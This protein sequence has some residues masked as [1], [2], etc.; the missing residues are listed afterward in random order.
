MVVILAEAFNLRPAILQVSLMQASKVSFKSN[1]AP[2][3]FSHGLLHIFWFSSIM[4]TLSS[5]LQM[6]WHLFGL[7]FI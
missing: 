6:K 5:V 7:T 4:L 1:L 2:K 3:S